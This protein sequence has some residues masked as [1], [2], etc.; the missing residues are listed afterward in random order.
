MTRDQLHVAFRRL[1]ARVQRLLAD[2]NRRGLLMHNETKRISEMERMDGFTKDPTHTDFNTVIV[3]FDKI[4]RIFSRLGD[5]S[6]FERWREDYAS[7]K[8]ACRSYNGAA[9]YE[10]EDESYLDDED[11]DDD[12]GCAPRE[13]DDM[14]TMDRRRAGPPAGVF[15][16]KDLVSGPLYHGAQVAAADEAGKLVLDMGRKFLGKQWPEAFNTPK[17]QSLAKIVMASLIKTLAH[18]GI[19]PMDT[20]NLC[21]ACDLV[22]EGAARDLVQP[23]MVEL[24]PALRS[25]ATLTPGDNTGEAAE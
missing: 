9:E 8:H 7:W 6:G 20:V 25:L 3:A 23:M 13:A 16:M 19:L 11:D 21:K 4:S 15:G 10:E 18:N 1:L 2:A 12:G 14:A 22:L 5:Y 24:S 17:G